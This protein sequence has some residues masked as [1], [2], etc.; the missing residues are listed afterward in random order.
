MDDIEWWAYI[1][2]NGSLIVKRY[3]DLGDIIEAL[4][5]DFVEKVYGPVP[6]GNRRSAEFYFKSKVY[7]DKHD[8]QLR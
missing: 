2:I 5:S 8:G 6:L 4:R 7:E 3:F 1:H